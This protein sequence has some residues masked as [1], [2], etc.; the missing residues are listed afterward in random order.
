MAAVS[1]LTEEIKKA[2][3]PVGC[4][5]KIT[6]GR[7]SGQSCYSRR[8]AWAQVGVSSS[9]VGSEI[10]I[11]RGGGQGSL[12]S[13]TAITNAEA[14]RQGLRS[15]SFYFSGQQTEA[16]ET[17]GLTKPVRRPDRGAA[18]RTVRTTARAAVRWSP[19]VWGALDML[20]AASAFALGHYLT[21]YRADPLKYNLIPGA[22]T[23]AGFILI[24]SY[25]LGVYD[26][27]NFTSVAR[28]ARQATAVNA[29]ALAATCLAF[30]WFAYAPIGRYA[31]L[32]TFATSTGLILLC[33]MVAR[34]LA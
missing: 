15:T 26:R 21:P 3:H 12:G 33:R 25:V 24:F 34:E 30:L 9:L 2:L 18:D 22:A 11:R 16:A 7:L 14:L 28:I 27:H 23:F 19:R 32:G 17:A 20:V 10:V 29:L 1:D 13:M 31:A 4:C 6:R 8:T 5:G